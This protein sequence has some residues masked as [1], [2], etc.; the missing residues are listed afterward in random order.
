MVTYNPWNL[1]GFSNTSGRN[2]L[3]VLITESS[4]QVQWMIGT[5]MLF[6]IWIVFFFA[7]KTRGSLTIDAAMASSFLCT[8][9]AIL[10]Y[11]L[12]ALNPLMLVLF[13][14]LTPITVVF[15]FFQG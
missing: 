5:G 3:V 12:G 13:I 8:V 6:A 14:M 7:L 4:K 9:I 11:A 10:F 1:T 2:G 15:K